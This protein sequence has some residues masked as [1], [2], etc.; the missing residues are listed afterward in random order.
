MDNE[1]M[2]NNII[3]EETFESSKIIEITENVNKILE[4]I[5]V[6]SYL[7][8]QN[9]EL[10]SEL[11]K[12]QS[13]LKK[14]IITPILKK[15]IREYERVTQQFEYYDKKTENDPQNEL[16]AKLLNEFKI[17]ALCML[18]LLEDY[19]ITSFDAKK[20]DDHSPAE[21]KIIN[22]IETENETLNKKIANCVSCGF[23]DIE[24]GRLLRQAEVDIYKF[25]NK[26]LLKT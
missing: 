18:D 16:F 15:V 25:T 14:E 5:Q 22:I 4:Q 23:R 7:E 6:F 1:L 12:Y 10:H 2:E 26:K 24:T 9:R 21:H 3:V 8:L 20:G 19:D 17:V 13:G 11:Q